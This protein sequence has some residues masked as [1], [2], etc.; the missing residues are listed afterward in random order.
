[1]DEQRVGLAYVRTAQATAGRVLEM[2]AP[3]EGSARVLGLPQMFGPEQ[4]A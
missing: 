4:E 3:A 2:E 1:V